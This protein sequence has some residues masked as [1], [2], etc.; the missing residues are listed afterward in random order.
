MSSLIRWE[1]FRAL[2]LIQSRLGRLMDEIDSTL[3]TNLTEPA[4]VTPRVDITED[5]NTLYYV[6]ELPGVEREDIHV[7]VENGILTVKGQ[8][9]RRAEASD[10]AP[11]RFELSRGE[12]V[13]SFSLPEGVNSDM[14]QAELENG[15]L[16][17]RIPLPESTHSK[18]RE[19]TV[20]CGHH[21][22]MTHYG[23]QSVV[24]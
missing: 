15:V 7:Q 4:I 16:E 9:L 19:I 14:I 13:R 2:N 12:F 23:H 5:L 22:P 3:A 21:L 1:P 8:K 17:V 11:H 24:S 10:R 20:S 18:P 6:M